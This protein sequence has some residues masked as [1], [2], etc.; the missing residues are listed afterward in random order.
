MID[1][2]VVTR[3]Y[4]AR[5]YLY[6]YWVIVLV[7]IQYRLFLIKYG[8]YQHHQLLWNAFITKFSFQSCIYLL[9]NEAA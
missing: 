6:L 3:P 7:F 1:S 5:R 9:E 2:I 8:V 4:V